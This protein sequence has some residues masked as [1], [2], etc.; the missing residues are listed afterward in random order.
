MSNKAI[1]KST[2]CRET[3]PKKNTSLY[4]HS[5]I[6]IA[7]IMIF[8]FLPAI[9]PITPLGMKITG[10]FLGMIYLWTTVSVLWPS[11]FGLIVIALSG[12][13]G[14]GVAALKSVMLTAF[15]TDTVLLILFVMILFGAMDEAGCTSYIVRWFLTRKM[16]TG[17]P[18]VF[19]FIF[20]FTCY[21]LSPLVN[22]ITALLLLWPISLQLMA[23]LKVERCDKIW[24][25]FY[26][27]MFF[28]TTIGLPFFPFMGS[29]LIVLSA[30]DQMTNHAYSFSF[31]AYM[32][33]NF[34][35]SM[36][37]LLVYL[38][39]LRFI[40]RVDVSKLRA[41]N[42]Q[43]IADQQQ[44]PKMNFQ[45]KALML[46]I[47]CYIVLLLAPSIFPASFPGIKLL[48]SLG[49]LG[50]TMCWIV[51]FSI[52]RFNGQE[53]L[54]FKE[55]A[56]KK[57]DWSIFFLIAACIYSSNA[58]AADVTGVKIFLVQTLNPL[59]GGQSELGF[60]AI[61]FTV[62]LIL[63]NFANNA[64]MAVIL[65]PVVLAFCEQLN[66]AP[67]PV[68]MGITMMVFV[69]MLTPAASPHAGMMHSRKD[70]YASKDILRIGLP[71]CLLTL[72]FYIFIGYPLAKLFFQ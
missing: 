10:V 65:M 31:F 35:M 15:G 33:L 45:Q 2:E 17:R 6:G 34:I 22:P 49:P 41:V 71:L 27:G 43:E 61:M 68:V 44:L 24:P 60:V 3:S 70:I 36:S 28:V 21:A 11:L 67:L 46:M 58:M 16:I 55:V 13:A 53:I 5:L 1:T 47:P 54:N 56:Y 39:F 59:L 48:A 50:L 63:T 40:I 12:Y 66:I 32:G 69:A 4:V 72:V 8:Q 64:G 7:F 37:V 20:Y 14:E 26:V 51:F 29:Q 18:Y 25:F 30:F 38:L 62:A 57:F 52:V 42:A 19:L 9:E 23:I